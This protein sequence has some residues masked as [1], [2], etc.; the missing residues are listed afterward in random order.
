MTLKQYLSMC[1][2]YPADKTMWAEFGSAF[3]DLES[4]TVCTRFTLRDGYVRIGD[5]MTAAGNGYMV[6][7]RTVK[8]GLTFH[9]VKGG[10]VA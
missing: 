4:A 5:K 3:A 6:L 7:I 8:T 2:L 9:K 1:K 10:V